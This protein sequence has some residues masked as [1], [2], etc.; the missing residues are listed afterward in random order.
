MHYSKI[1]IATDL[2]DTTYPTI[3]KGVALAQ[4]FNAD[5]LLVH[6]IE[7]IPAY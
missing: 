5:I 3:E 2:S 6:V 4:S 1:L 7:P